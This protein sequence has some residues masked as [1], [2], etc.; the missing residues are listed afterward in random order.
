MSDGHSEIGAT[1]L[2]VDDTP[3]NIRLLQAVLG[4]HGYTVVDA[5]SGEE[6]LAKVALAPPDIVLLDVQMSGMDG[7]EVCRTLRAEPATRFLPVVMVTSSD[8]ADRLSAMEAGADDFVQKPF[9]QHELLVRVR[10][11]VRIKQ[12]HDTIE[13]QAAELAALNADLEVRVDEQVTQLQRLMVLKR[14]LSPALAELV[15]STGESVLESHRREI[16]VLFG[17]LRGWTAFSSS[18]EPEEVMGVIRQYHETL[19]E[20]IRRS[21]ATVGWFAGDGVMVWFNDPLPCDEPARRAVELAVDMRTGMATRASDW[22]RRGH[23]LDF[24][25]GVALG[26]ATLG[27]MGFEGRYEYGAIG[28]VLN[29]A[30]R[31]C[32]EAAPGEILV[33]DRAIAELDGA[34]DTEAVGPLTLKGFAKPVSAFRVR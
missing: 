6:A 13:A 17:D 7:Y 11:L 34:F 29:L 21:D 12:Y 30:S 1:V 18:T 16:A 19:G 25:V 8:S 5:A 31:L 33:N 10:S 27:T 9:N 26:Y 24:S 23:E 28:S 3:Q 15:L 32:D 20:L 14:F 4:G 2:V 22:Q